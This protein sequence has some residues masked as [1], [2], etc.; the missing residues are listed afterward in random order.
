MLFSIFFYIFVE[1]KMNVLIVGKNGQLG[2]T[3]VDMLANDKNHSF[4]FTNHDEL[5]I[6]VEED[7]FNYINDN[8]I[9]IVINC[10]AYTNVRESENKDNPLPL[11]V[12]EM[13]VKYLAES[14]RH[15][16]GFMIHI[17]TDYVYDGTKNTPYVETDAVNP[18]NMYGSSK[19]LGEANLDLDKDIIIRTSWLYS[20]YGHNFVDTII[21][22]SKVKKEIEVVFD[23]VGTPT[24]ARDLAKVIIK[25]I[26][27]P[28]GG[29]YHYS[30]E[31]VCSWYDFAKE[32]LEITNS[33]CIVKPSKTSFED[34]KRPSYSVLDK[35][36]IKHVLSVNIPYW[37]DSLR[38]MLT[39]I[40]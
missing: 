5:D 37:K 28:K 29:I 19:C 11:M 10:A 21:N 30:N 7:V 14:I 40:N 6:C 27:N 13:A 18:L 31:G 38:T 15:R 8:K 4:F 39:K 33:E 1:K 32:I 9:D 34:L 36:K 25:F 35:S 12:N 16:G 23:Q 2:K 26:D 3:L 24:Y 22:L 17:S 20:D